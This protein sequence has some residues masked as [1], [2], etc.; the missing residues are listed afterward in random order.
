MRERA[1]HPSLVGPLIL[2]TIGVLLLLNQMGRLRWDVL[3]SLWRYWPVILILLGIETLIGISESRVVRLL[4]LLIALVVL[5]GLISYVMLQGGATPSQR[6]A[7][8]TETVSQGLQDA[9]RGLVTLRL[10]AGAVSVGALSDSPNFVEAKIEYSARSR[11]VVQNFA[12]RNG[13][14]EFELRGD[15]ENPLWTSGPG[16]DETWQVRLTPRVPLDMRID[17]GA[18]R[19][20]ADLSGLQVTQLDLDMG[21]GSTTLT[22]PAVDGTATVS[23]NLAVG[24]VTVVIPAGVGVKMRA[25]KLLSSVN[26]AGQRLTRSGDEWVSPNYATATSKVDL[27]IDN[28]IGSINVR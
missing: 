8:D 5:G 22:L 1:R 17:T 24:E 14:A 6:P 10:A 15:L 19:V 12:V 3:W 7:A 11:Q 13:R 28:V 4:G 20:E 21:V 16:A 23:V 2:I 27:R 18:G 9:E 26:I 25:N